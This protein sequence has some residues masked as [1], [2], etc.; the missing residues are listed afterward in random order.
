[1]K[2]I[3]NI[4]KL[5]S[6]NKPI[7]K[8]LS[9]LPP[10]SATNQASR[11]NE[12]QS[13]KILNDN[14]NA[15]NSNIKSTDE[16]QQALFFLLSKE[17]EHKSIEDKKEFLK[18]KISEESIDE[19]LSL[20]PLVNKMISLEKEKIKENSINNNANTNT[21]NNNNILDYLKGFS[22]YSSLIFAT[23]GINYLFD[24]VRN[25]KNEV[26]YRNIETKLN[27]EINN[28]STNINKHFS[29]EMSNYVKKDEFGVFYETQ[30]R[31]DS[32]SKGLKLNPLS[33]N[34]KTQVKQLHE[35]VS[36]LK[37]KLDKL[38]NTTEN[39]RIMIKQDI[40]KECE[41]I[42]NKKN[43]EIVG[44]IGEEQKEFLLKINTMLSKNLEMMNNLVINKFSN[45]V[46]NAN[47]NDAST[48]NNLKEIEKDNNREY[49]NNNETDNNMLKD[50]KEVYE[51]EQ[52]IY[53]NKKSN[54]DDN[55]DN[56][57]NTGIVLEKFNKIID[58]I[59]DESK[60]TTFINGITH[61]FNTFLEEEDE[62]KFVSFTINLTNPIY[63]FL[64]Q[65]ENIGEFLMI[66]GFKKQN[67]MKFS[68]ENRE[69]LEKSYDAI[70]TKSS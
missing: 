13:T 49:L 2:K 60:R 68:L 29:D 38:S 56:D 36:S 58:N 54:M 66:S 40:V 50:N 5:S 27:T 3:D 69:S 1:M 23:L 34:T 59:S 26:F 20:L 48:N 15:S 43:E 14:N 12:E 67:D 63:K 16:V 55:E 47:N 9:K 22:I 39:N 32:I 10:T 42:I 25:K 30:N 44:K 8:I 28:L 19:A 7:D 51:E 6:Y 65:K 18:T 31:E 37:V 33:Q 41:G 57:Y 64:N 11:E 53:K 46:N 45:N 4:D 21:N 35:D 24:L 62:E 61:Q 70:K 17:L 52:N